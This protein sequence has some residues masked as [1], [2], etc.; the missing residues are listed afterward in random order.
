LCFECCF[1]RVSIADLVASF[2]SDDGFTVGADIQ[3]QNG[4]TNFN[5]VGFVTVGTNAFS[6]DGALTIVEDTN[7]AAGTITGAFSPRDVAMPNSASTTS[8]QV[9][10]DDLAGADYIV[11]GQSITETLAAYQVNFGFQGNILVA[12]GTDFIDTGTAYLQQ[13]YAEVRID[14]D[15][16]GATEYFYNGNLIHSGST[17][18][19]SRV[20]I[21]SFASDN[22]QSDSFTTNPNASFDAFSL[23]QTPI[24]EPAS[25]CLLTLVGL[26][27]TVVRRRR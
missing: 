8:M 22:F 23:T 9:Y 6:G 2:D 5:A 14:F 19:A 4:W 20:E 15:P 18:G 11:F 12:E 13:Q 1:C 16:V 21:V 17:I 7:V 3:G 25:A 24:P 27:M 26:A 10:I